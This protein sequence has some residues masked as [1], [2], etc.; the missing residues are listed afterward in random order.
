MT[1]GT[2]PKGLNSS[3]IYLIPKVEQPKLVTDFRSISLINSVPKLF[4]KLM[5]ER[6][7]VVLG[8]LISANQFGFMKGKLA[9]E[10]ILVVNEVCHSLKMGELPGSS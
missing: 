5:A 2:F 10:S 6:V 4:M 7:N 9:S 3:F 8:K 1:K